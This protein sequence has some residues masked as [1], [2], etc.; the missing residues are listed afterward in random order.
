MM[1]DVTTPT[2]YSSS[3]IS[4]DRDFIFGLL[5]G[6]KSQRN[7]TDIDAIESSPIFRGLGRGREGGLNPQ[8]PVLWAPQ[9]PSCCHLF[10]GE[11]LRGVIVVSAESYVL[12]LK[13]LMA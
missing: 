7:F 11:I 4:S 13:M 2:V 10:D 12:V 5:A 6:D 1:E 8:L 3:S 9:T